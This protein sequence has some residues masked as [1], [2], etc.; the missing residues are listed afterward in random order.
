MLKLKLQYFGHLL[1]RANSLEKTLMPGK[2]ECRRRSTGGGQQ[3]FSIS[4]RWLDGITDSMDMNLSKLWETV[5]DREAC[6][7]VVH[8]SQEV[9]LDWVTKNQLLTSQPKQSPL[10]CAHWSLPLGLCPKKSHV[11]LHFWFLSFFKTMLCSIGDL[12]SPTRDQ[13]QDPCIG[14][15]VLTTVPPGKSLITCV[16]ITC[17][18]RALRF[19]HCSMDSDPFHFHGGIDSPSPLRSICF[20]KCRFLR[21]RPWE[22]FLSLPVE[23]SYPIV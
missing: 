9:G 4:L 21:W 6:Q 8:G 14:S 18:W 7:A 3:S 10:H 16:F 17:I 12:S 1:Q 20:P 5:Q 2:I 13:T 22:G 15:T 23:F 11:V 19:R